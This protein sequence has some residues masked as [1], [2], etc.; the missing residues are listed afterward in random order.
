MII[1]IKETGVLMS[2]QEFK[3]SHPNTSFPQQLTE[4]LINELGGDIVFEGTQIAASTP[5]E[6][7][8]YSGVEEINGKWYKKYTLGPVFTD[9]E[10]KTA[11]QQLDTYKT[12]LDSQQASR[13]RHDRNNL[14][15]QS[16][17]TQTLDAATRCN[18]SA[19]ASYRQSLA[20]ITKQQG[21][22]WNVIWPTQPE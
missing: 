3:N 4:A 14:L 20:D 9:T 7:T 6:Y 5:Y 1:R 22:P 16:D 17:W 18:Q 8:M 15:K 10:D 19:W 21:F 11:E 12:N 13:V 2:D